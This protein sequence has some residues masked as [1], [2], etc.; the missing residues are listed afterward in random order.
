MK[1]YSAH[2]APGPRRAL[3]ALAEKGITDVEVVNLDLAAGDNLTDEFSRMNP[4]KKVPVLEL[5]SGE[6]IAEAGAIYRYLEE[7]CPQPPLLGTGAEQKA[8][9][10]M[11]DRR[12]EQYFLM[13]VGQCFQHSS[14]FFKDRMTPVADWGQECGRQAAAFLPV[15]EAQ[16]QQHEFV[17]GEVF[18]VADITAVCTLEFARIISL[19]PGEEFPAIQRWHE[20]L[21]QRRGYLVL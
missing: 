20:Q 12:L 1:L 2:K 11:W 21:K 9:I 17:A 16:L 10:E 8:R 18:S 3:M 7:I 5:D 4:M 13:P 6:C 19:R 14:G 15:L